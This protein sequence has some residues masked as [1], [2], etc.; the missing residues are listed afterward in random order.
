MPEISEKLKISEV[1]DSEDERL[2]EL[3]YPYNDTGWKKTLT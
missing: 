2:R 1:S 3:T